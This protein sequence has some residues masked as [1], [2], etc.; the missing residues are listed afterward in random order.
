MSSKKYPEA[1]EMPSFCAEVW[2]RQGQKEGISWAS[3]YFL[4][5]I[6]SLK[7]VFI[8]NLI[9]HTL[10]TPRR[11]MRKALMGTVL[12]AVI[13]RFAFHIGLAESIAKLTF[14]PYMLGVWQIY[15]GTQQVA[16][17]G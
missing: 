5:L 11:L 1:H 10:E 16:V 15:C 4:E 13:L 7:D 12:G 2:I 9:F 8:F 17:S 14:L 3:G 6:Y